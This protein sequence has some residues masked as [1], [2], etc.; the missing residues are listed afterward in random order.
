[1]FSM[2]DVLVKFLVE[3][4]FRIFMWMLDRAGSTAP[5]IR[6]RAA[7]RKR[8]DRYASREGRRAAIEALRGATARRRDVACA[9]M[10]QLGRTRIARY[11]PVIAAVCMT[12][13]LGAPQNDDIRV[14]MARS[15]SSADAATLFDDVNAERA[16]RGLPPLVRD[17]QLEEYAARLARDLLRRHREQKQEM[18]EPTQ[19]HH[20]HIYSMSTRKLAS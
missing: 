17:R 2:N 3:F 18:E 10:R 16:T 7:I 8:F 12:A 6:A 19:P 5:V 9:R 14:S 1:M 11:A 15:T 20:G 4:A 13:I